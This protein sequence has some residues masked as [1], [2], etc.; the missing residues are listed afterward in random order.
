[1]LSS[2][3]VGPASKIEIGASPTYGPDVRAQEPLSLADDAV[4]I[5]ADLTGLGAG[6]HYLWI[7]NNRGGRSEPF[8]L[9]GAST[10]STGAGA[11]GS[12]G[13]S[14]AAGGSPGSGPGPGAGAGGA[15]GNGQTSV[16]DGGCECR[17]AEARSRSAPAASIMLALGLTLLRRRRRRGTRGRAL[18]ARRSA[19]D[20]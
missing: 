9:S 20:A 7:T 14:Q 8:D 1:M 15:S 17:A 5:R 2:S 3:R 18:S 6:P 13:A 11:G 4:A 19:R 16:D 10:G 12:G